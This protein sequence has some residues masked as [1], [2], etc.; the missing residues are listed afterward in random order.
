M[1][2]KC[3][4]TPRKECGVTLPSLFDSCASLLP[5]KFSATIFYLFII[6][7]TAIKEDGS[8]DNSCE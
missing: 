8:G 2:D 4:L 7:K 3:V 5:Q 1:K 6:S